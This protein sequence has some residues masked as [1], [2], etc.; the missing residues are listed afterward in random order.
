MNAGSNG[1][2]LEATGWVGSD[3][4]VQ[5]NRE[6]VGGGRGSQDL[7]RETP[8]LALGVAG[9]T[10]DSLGCSQVPPDYIVGILCTECAKSAETCLSGKISPLR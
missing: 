8:G 9:D 10:G 4:V 7:Y 5:N 3:L 2:R 6:R 1:Q